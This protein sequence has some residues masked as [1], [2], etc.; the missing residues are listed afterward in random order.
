[1]KIQEKKLTAIIPYENNPRNNDEAVQ[2]VANSIKEFGFKQPIVIDLD[3]TIIAGHTRYKAAKKLGLDTVPCVVASDLTPEQV[4]AYRLADNKVSEFATWD[5]DLLNEELDGLFNIDMEEFGFFDSIEINFSNLDKMSSSN[6]E[7]DEFTEKFKPK[8]TTDDCYT[9]EDVYEEVK[10]WAC[11]EYGVNEEDIVRPFYPGGDYERFKYK[12]NSVVID[13][14]PFSIISEICRF[15]DDR[16]IKYFL[17][18][19]SL[20]LFSIN[21][22][23]ENYIVCNCG[24][25]YE[26]GANVSTSFVTNMGD[27]KIRTAPDLLKKIQEANFKTTKDL[28]KYEYPTSV[29][30]AALLVKVREVDLSIKESECEFIRGLDCQ[31]ESKTGI[32]GSGFIISENASARYESAIEKNEEI[33]RQKE[34]EKQRQKEIEKLVFE[35]S[36]REK[37][38][39]ASLY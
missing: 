2:Y 33:K 20:T 19:P 14:P 16:G 24:V 35:L 17:F 21:S 8:K 1:M 18:A 22:G 7:Y 28:P 39:R 31:K 12:K 38:I 3:G 30:S 13:N 36:E 5:I 32:Y 37:E 9:P 26:N 34:I 4:N 11:K 29:I 27:I 23:K 10:N 15:Y 6:E 25:I